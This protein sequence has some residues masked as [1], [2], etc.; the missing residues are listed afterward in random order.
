MTERFTYRICFKTVPLFSIVTSDIAADR[1]VSAYSHQQ[2]RIGQEDAINTNIAIPVEFQFPQLIDVEIH[3]V[4][5]GKAKQIAVQALDALN[6]FLEAPFPVILRQAQVKYTIFFC[7]C[8]QSLHLLL[9]LLHEFVETYGFHRREIRCSLAL[10]H[11][12]LNNLERGSIENDM[13]V[14]RAGCDEVKHET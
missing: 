11:L 2:D 5:Q 3:F 4:L 13:G 10:V 8:Q 14:L 12:A 7:S 6:N 9:G 1:F